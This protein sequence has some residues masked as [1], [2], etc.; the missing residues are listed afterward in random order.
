VARPI[1]R[2]QAEK[3]KEQAAAFM[4]RI[5]ESSRAAEFDEM[6]TDEYIEHRGLQV[7]NPRNRQRRN[8]PMASNTVSKADLQASIDE[9]VQILEDAYAPESTR[10]DLAAAV[11]EAL[12]T[13]NGGDE[14]DDS[15]DDDSDDDT[16]EV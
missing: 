15:D 5:G 4:E 16:D 9:A 12:D 7:S 14:D 6:S 10:E 3:K 11:G 13:L 1:T 8:Q 2:E